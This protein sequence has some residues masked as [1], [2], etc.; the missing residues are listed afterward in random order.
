M[1]FLKKSLAIVL[2]VVMGCMSI[3]GCSSSAS[4]TPESTPEPT[5]TATAT[6][7]PEPTPVP[8][9]TPEVIPA[10]AYFIV[11]DGEAAAT[12]VYAEKETQM[13]RDAVAEIRA[14]LDDECGFKIPVW[15]DSKL[16]RIK[17]DNVFYVGMTKRT[18]LSRLNN[19][20]ATSYQYLADKEG[21]NVYLMSYTQGGILDAVE[22]IRDN[23]IVT[24]DGKNAY[25]T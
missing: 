14:M 24:S 3:A 5:P 17:T 13:I 19:C 18:E 7:T 15:E 23:I 16:S 2:V 10:D 9:P 1:N 6:P 20:K 22:S 21:T 4:S 12:F 11:Q 25:V 8:T